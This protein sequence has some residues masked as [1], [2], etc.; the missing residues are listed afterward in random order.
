M[1]IKSDLIPTPINVEKTNWQEAQTE[2][3]WFRS[4][5]LPTHFF[6]ALSMG[7]P[8]SERFLVRNLM[9]VILR[10]SDDDLR[11]KLRDFIE[12][13]KSHSLQHTKFNQD[14]KKHGYPIDWINRVMNLVYKLMSHTFSMKT[15][16]AM[17]SAME[18]M[19]AVL[20]QW[21]LT[22]DMMFDRDCDV[23]DLF[24]WHAVEELSHRSVIFDVYQYMGGGYIRR[25]LSML[26]ISGLLTFG[27]VSV[28]WL[29]IL[30]DVI[31]R[32]RIKWRHIKYGWTFFLGRQGMIRRCLKHYLS[33]Y[34][35]TYEP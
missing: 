9:P 8:E 30:I 24:I 13:E 26:F 18:H 29:F 7:I 28:Q 1:M 15:K 32:R 21:G 34:K 25:M 11:Q 16:L 6:N 2:L 31:K 17:M 10:V 14:L 27:I 33:Y 19:T 22:Y 23:Y 5:P 35:T 4:Q 20:A 3:Y 12:E